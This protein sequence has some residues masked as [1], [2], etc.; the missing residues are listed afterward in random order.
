MKKRESYRIIA[1]L[2]LVVGLVFSPT[3]FV[4]G[5]TD[6][7]PEEVVNEP[8]ND[9]ID[10]NI[11]EEQG[12]FDNQN[13]PEEEGKQYEKEAHDE[14]EEQIDQEESVDQ[15]EQV[16]Q[17]KQEDLDV[18]TVLK[19]DAT[20][21]E[22]TLSAPAMNDNVP[23]WPPKVEPF[24]IEKR[25]GSFYLTG[26]DSSVYQE[27]D[28]IQ[29]V[30]DKNYIIKGGT[31]E[32]LTGFQQIDD[33]TYYAYASTE[34]EAGYLAED[35]D[36]L[37]P[38]EDKYYYIKNGQFNTYTGI[39]HK[40]DETGWFSVKN[41]IY[42][43]DFTGL[44]MREDNGKYYYVENGKYKKEF[45]GIARK[46]DEK[47]GWFYAKD[48]KYR[49]TFTGLANKPGTENYYF[50]KNGKY[51]KSFTGLAKSAHAKGYY[52]AENGKYKRTYTGLAG[53]ID[54][55]GW[56]F[57]KNGKYNTTFKGLAR[58]PGTQNYY[59]VENGR[60]T[61]GFTGLAKSAHAKGYYY[62][63]DSK[64]RRT[65][66]GLTEKIDAKG[67]HFAKNGKYDTKFKGLARKPGTKD[68]YYVEN[69][70][71]TKGFTGLTKSAHAEGNYY[72]KNSK[73]NP[74]FTGIA[75]IQG[76]DE[77]CYIKKG[78]V[79]KNS[80]L[81]LTQDG[82][83]WL[84]LESEVIEVKTESDKTLYRAFKYIDKV[85]SPG[86]TRDEKRKTIFTFML[87]YANLPEYNPRIPHYHGDDWPIIYANDVFV[88]NGGNCIS[89]GAAF[90]YMGKAL[91]YK[92]V[93]A[94]HSGGHGW[95]ELEGLIY[96]P[97]WARHGQYDAFAY[98]GTTYSPQK[99][100]MNYWGGIAGGRSWQRVAL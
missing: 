3:T 20:S 73:Y 27:N 53:K 2:I 58:K 75:K 43:P 7:E 23:S 89:F 26:G 100:E 9:T 22:I 11:P 47:A 63:K 36:A 42:V 72:A 12:D 1:I 10:S 28:W 83:Q 66:T 52:Y 33:I 81:A 5:E 21:E 17:E 78:K 54:A 71:Y 64:Y 77:Y 69:G 13:I 8:A 86:M 87:S 24:S 88:N 15:E 91:G 79:D 97:E 65:Y 68:Y 44:A 39:V 61:K 29:L 30:G 55:K 4:Y 16:E 34:D 48:S 93:Y 60:Y 45:H 70:R 38:N 46:I 40:S 74:S 35:A 82:K 92:D 96:D 32:V 56:H 25:E 76:K 57:A 19:N 99:T 6:V 98:Y 49:P 51:D 95:A 62:A 50:V 85:T 37:F 59:Y 80:R 14:Q 90:A 41:G 67:W 94:C 18:D 31:Y 84:V